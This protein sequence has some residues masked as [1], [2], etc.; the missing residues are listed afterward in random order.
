MLLQPSLPASRGFLSGVKHAYDFAHSIVK[1]LSVD[2]TS[3]AWPLGDGRDSVSCT[4]SGRL[5]TSDECADGCDGMCGPGCSC[6]YGLCD[7]CCY[8]ASCH[9]HDNNCRP[10]MMNANCITFRGA[11]WD[12]PPS[13]LC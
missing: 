2:G 4:G 6:W 12:R 8:H 1:P 7:D 5:M 3:P 10:T 13:G 11:G 9:K